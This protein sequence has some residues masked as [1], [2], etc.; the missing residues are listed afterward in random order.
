M[1]TRHDFFTLI[2]KGQRRELFAATVVAGT[3][4]WEDA[5]SAN[6]FV[7]LW[8]KLASMLEAHAGHEHNHVFP[9]LAHHA[10]ET[11]EHVEAAHEDLDHR[12]VTLTDTIARAAG[13]RSRADGLDVYRE[14][15]AFVAVYLLH[16]LD[17]ETLVM[18]AIWRHCTDAE[19]NAARSNLQADQSA[20]GAT[21]SRRAI[22][23]AIT[24]IERTTMA[25]AIRRGSTNEAFAAFMSD[26]RQVLEAAACDRLQH[27]LLSTSDHS[28]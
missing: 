28:S 15:T 6:D 9:L 5:S 20:A 12:L 24:D 1:S 27:S 22:L 25:L 18:P 23:P 3:T 4:D 11:V 8:S 7:S 16:I 10:P 2:H 26:A 14:L 19:I 13:Q 21:R 17:E